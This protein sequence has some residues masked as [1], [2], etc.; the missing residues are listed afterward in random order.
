M[1]PSITTLA[2][3]LPTPEERQIAKQLW[4]PSLPIAANVGIIEYNRVDGA[5]FKEKVEER[6]WRVLEELAGELNVAAGLVRGEK[7]TIESSGG[8]GKG[9]ENKG[10]DE[11]GKE[12][13]ELQT[14][15]LGHLAQPVALL[16]KTEARSETGTSETTT[17]GGTETQTNSDAVA[18]GWGMGRDGDGMGGKQQDGSGGWDVGG[19]G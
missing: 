3:N 4:N 17:E 2:N 1:P 15:T 6:W 12:A 10:V 18:D 16:P 11:S 5:K 14:K 19:D 9:S 8:Q 7:Q 13:Q